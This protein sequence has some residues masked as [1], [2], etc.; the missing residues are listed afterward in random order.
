MILSLGPVEDKIYFFQKNS[1]ASVKRWLH[2][3]EDEVISDSPD[4][5][6]GQSN[7]I[8]TKWF[9]KLPLNLR[10]D[11]KCASMRHEAR[12]KIPPACKGKGA[13]EEQVISGLKGAL[14]TKD[15]GV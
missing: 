2:I 10:E 11:V 4:A 8:H 1:P 15:T 14:L 12:T 7:H 5:P 3:I 6:T 9:I 13:V